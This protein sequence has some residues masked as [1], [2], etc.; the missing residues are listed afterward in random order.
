MSDNSKQTGAAATPNPDRTE[1]TGTA[2]SARTERVPGSTGPA[3]TEITRQI[4]GLV[5]DCERLSFYHSVRCDWF[6][7][8]HR[9]AMFLVVFS[10][11]SA[12]AAI[13][14]L[15]AGLYLMLLPAALGLLDLTFNL[16]GRAR[17]HSALYQRFCWLRGGGYGWGNGAERCDVNG[18]GCGWDFGSCIISRGATSQKNERDAK[19]QIA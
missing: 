16:S 5:F 11:T 10:G 12:F 3:A 2:N 9:W 15:S 6:E 1:A 18:C 4:D 17:E 8:S 7:R 14:S 13:V 19:N